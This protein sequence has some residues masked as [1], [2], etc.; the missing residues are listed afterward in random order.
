MSG[1]LNLAAASEALKKWYLPG[2]QYQMNNSTPLL[3]VMERDSESVAGDKIV[4]A[5]RYGRAGGIGNR[6]DDGN[7]PTPNSR[8]TKQATW[9]TKNLYA[10]IQITD[11]TMKASRSNRG[12]FVSLLEADLDDCMTDAK[13]NMSR[14]VFGNGTGKLATCAV[15]TTTVT[16]TLDSV[17]FL[18]EGMLVDVCSSVGVVAQAEREIL[19]VD[20]VAKT[21]KI[22]GTAITTAATDILVVSGSYGLE[23]TGLESIFTA[24][25][26]LY[27]V[28]R[29]QNKWFNSTNRNIAGEIS[30]VA[31]QWAEDEVDRKAGS[32]INFWAA[33]YGVRR[34]YQ[35]LL[36]ATKQLIQPMQLVGGWNVLTY[37]GQAFTTDKYAP[38]NTIYGLD[39]ST[40]RL[41]QMEDFSW[42]DDDGAVLRQVP[43]KPIWA[44]ALSRYCDIGCSKPRG[45]VKLTGITE[46]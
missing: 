19:I 23:M 18:M 28:D 3:S 7:L 8:K 9:D 27:G 29:S 30:E 11:K 33:S 12:A 20:D 1:A 17:Q 14:Q 2:M 45:S 5:L 43:G 38:A 42:M 41:Y 6:A 4:M 31:L 40:F 46:H 15:N 37:N 32:K 10:Q 34:S 44:A 21:V 13:D 24:D 39:M 36:L 22:S 16:L 35:N 26:T 25:N